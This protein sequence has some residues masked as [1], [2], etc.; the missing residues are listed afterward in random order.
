MK[1]KIGISAR[2]IHLTE[3]DYN[4]LF[5]EPVKA[6]NPIN[7]PGQFSTKETV[8]LING[9]KKIEN[10]RM[11]GPTRPYTQVELSKTDAHNLRLDLP[12]KMSGDLEE[13]ALITIKTEK[14]QITRKA[15]IISAR[16]IHVTPEEKEKYGLTKNIYSVKIP[17]E[18]GGIM[19]NVYLSVSEKSY[20][21]MHIDTDD[22][23]A[24]LLNINDEVEI[25]N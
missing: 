2:H 8:T 10:V 25:L 20:Y 9:D 18:K 1:V 13:A 19:D 23:N 14:G 15:A 24:F 3:E 5:D 22:A 17:G 12:V 6:K 7:Q 21:E 16:H 11:I 4:L